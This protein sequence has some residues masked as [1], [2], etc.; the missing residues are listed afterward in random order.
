VKAD[1]TIHLRLH[2][3]SVSNLREHWTAKAARNVEHRELVREHFP[4]QMVDVLKGRKHY[5]CRIQFLRSAPRELDD[6]NIRPAFKAMRDEVCRLLGLPNDRQSD[7]LRFNYLQ[8]PAKGT[9]LASIRVLFD[10]PDEMPLG[11]LFTRAR[12]R[13]PQPRP[14]YVPPPKTPTRTHQE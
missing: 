10:L 14:S 9:S 13:T 6:D 3:E 11:P 5:Q 7:R 1:F 12:C 4:A 2:L 8:G